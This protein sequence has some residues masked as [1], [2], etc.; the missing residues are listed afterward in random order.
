MVFLSILEFSLL[1]TY[2][3]MRSAMSSTTA[4]TMETTSVGTA[5]KAR[6]PAGRKASGI[7]AV[8]KATKRAGVCSWLTVKTR[9]RVGRVGVVEVGVV[10]VAVIRVAAIK[11]AVIG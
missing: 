3:Y 10:E 8:I 7:S 1:S 2:V 11:S 5:S 6:L 4:T 9:R